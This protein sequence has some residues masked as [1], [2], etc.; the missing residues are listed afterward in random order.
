MSL[1][2]LSLF[3]ALWWNNRNIPSPPH[4]LAGRQSSHDLPKYMWE[5][6][7]ISILVVA[8]IPRP[9]TTI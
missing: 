4:Y 5:L 6:Q 7:L 2:R 3:H 1:L 8:E 9:D